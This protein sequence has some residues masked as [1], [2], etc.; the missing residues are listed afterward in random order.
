MK[1]GAASEKRWRCR[2]IHREA[3]CLMRSLPAVLLALWASLHVIVA[4]AADDAKRADTARGDRMLAAYF[5]NE[6]RK[7]ADDCLADVKSWDD[8]AAKRDTYRRQLREMLGLG[9]LPE[10]TPLQP[11]VTG[12][13]EHEEF[14]VENLHFQSRP[15]LYVTGNLYLPKK[16][17]GPAPTILYVCG[18]SKSIKHGVSYGNKTKYQ[19]HGAWFA[20]NGYVC[21][22][23]DTLQLGEI[24]GIHHGTHRENMWWWNARGYTPA[25]VEAWNC[26]RALDYLESRPEVDKQRI[27]VT[28]RSGG[29]AYSWYLAALDDRIKCL[30]PVAGITNLKNHVV[31][32]CVEGHCDCMYFV[33]TYRWDYP[34]LAALSAPRPLLLSN[35]DQDHIFPL[36][37]VLDVHDKLQHLYSLYNKRNHLGFHITV[38]PH[39]DTQVLQLHAFQW[40]NHHFKGDDSP[41]EDLAMPYFEPEQLKVFATLPAD[42]INTRVHETFV[43]LAPQASVPT[44]RDD[45][46]RQRD[47]WTRALREKCFA[48]WPA[49]PDSDATALH[50]RKSSEATAQGATFVAYDFESQHDVTLRL[51]LLVPENMKTKDVTSWRLE[52]LNEAGWT[53]FLAATGVGTQLAEETLPD[54]NANEFEKLQQRTDSGQGLAFIA[55]RGVGPTAW[56]STP[57]ERVHIKRRF[58]LL[59]QTLDGMRVW[60]VRRAI[61]ALRIIDGPGEIPIQ[62]TA[63]REMAGIALYAALFE[64]NIDALDLQDLPKSHRDGPDILNVL[65]FLDMPQTLAMVAEKTRVRIHQDG[66]NGWEYP[67][68]VTEKLGWKPIELQSS[69]GGQ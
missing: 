23:I 13:I 66:K 68:A 6:T 58:M 43:P 33:N 37:G 25:G 18:H 3:P 21:L 20:R 35:S 41:I 1:K 29:G 7:L 44:S 36:D 61:R 2:S 22:V 42:E 24:E 19:H 46:A 67:R 31:D 52:V 69:V 14:S 10:R 57:T 65:R 34:Q 49:D 27:G 16:L 40:F 45:W 39:E 38:G 15:H 12:K 26:I 63:E 59:G 28:G 62:I 47:Q 8:W 9:P 56:D 48:G 51:F 11:V 30:V 54:A 50:A 4:A 32:G 55:P 17:S 5:E 60:D 64:P 53:R